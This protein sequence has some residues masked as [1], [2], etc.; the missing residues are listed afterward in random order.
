MKKLLLLLL[1]VWNLLSCKNYLPQPDTSKII[2]TWRLLSR[3][4]K[5]KEGKILPETNLGSDPI[6]I[7][8]Y[9]AKGNM[10]VQIMRRNRKETTVNIRAEQNSN[11]SGGFDGYDAY[12]GTYVI[13]SINHQIKHIITGAIIQ[14]DVGKELVRNYS[15][16]GDTLTLWF[17]T[18]NTNIE[19]TR[20]LT[21]LLEN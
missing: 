6:A 8:F 17:T 15:I 9:D 11:N 10:S 18:S 12:F 14:K 13:D 2:G 7:L 16:S 5:T 4:D 21:W 19:L 20:T 1:I 3:T